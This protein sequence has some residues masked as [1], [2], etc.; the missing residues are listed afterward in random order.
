ME[1]LG[2]VSRPKKFE[3]LDT[4]LYEIDMLNFC[5]GQLCEGKWADTRSYYLCIEGFLLHYRNLSDF[6]GDHHNLKA[7]EP[8]A[9]SPKTLT[10][11]EVASIQ[12]RK[13]YDHYSG[14]ISQY[15]SH[16]TKSRANRDRDWEHIRMYNEI[17]PS[18]EKF[19]RLFPSRQLPLRA[20]ELLSA[21]SIST[22]TVSYHDL[23]NDLS[24]SPTPVLPT[25]KVG[26]DG[27]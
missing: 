5:Y 11:D 24:V 21:E 22:A 7:G 8:D 4:I 17:K 19:R 26:N 18:L 25:R 20:V 14:Q 15:L 23:F 10:S 1:N 13:P 27:E 2:A 16:C 6:F 9:W 3:H 12:D